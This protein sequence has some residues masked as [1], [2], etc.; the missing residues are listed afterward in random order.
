MIK[1]YTDLDNVAARPSILLLL[2]DLIAAARDSMS[3]NKS[4]DSESTETPLTPFKDEMLGIVSSALNIPA[5]RDP[6]LACLLGLVSTK[7]LLSDEELGFIVHNVDELLGEDTE[8]GEEAR[9]V[10]FNK[11]SV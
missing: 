5:A 6:A 10:I 11:N 2:S 4:D 8:Q 9:F 7:N 3:A 1:L